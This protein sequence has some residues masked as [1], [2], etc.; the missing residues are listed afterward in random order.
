MLNKQVKILALVLSAVFLL[1]FGRVFAR[2]GI[3]LSS[4]ISFSS[5]G[6]QQGDTLLIKI[7]KEAGLK[8]V[9]GEF[10]S[11]KI[12][13]LKSEAGD[14]IG[15]TGVDARTKSGKY[16]LVINLPGGSKY[17]KKFTVVKRKFPVTV[18]QVTKELKN[19]GYSPQSIIEDMASQETP[20]LN[21]ILKTYLPTAYF[22]KPF[23][24]PLSKV[25]IVG[26]FGNIRKNQGASF[27]HFGVDLDAEMGTPVYAVNDGIV[28]LTDSL[29]TYGKTMIIDH[30]LGI[31]SLYL[32][33]SEFKFSKGDKVKQGDVTGLSGNSGYSIAP[34]LH[35]SIKVNNSAIDPLLFV[36]T[37]MA[38]M[39][40]QK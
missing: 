8:E 37:S 40:N 17:E 36:E 20:V 27:Q 7:K 30:G 28:S 15:I 12:D 23:I 24:Y 14:W 6:L 16:N 29:P 32:H 10:L 19:Q 39:T 21:R 33:L 34:H 2:E 25:E 11:S 5:E 13:F 18:M 22:A 35:F 31:Y 38:E 4:E 26:D 9:S 3:L 1:G